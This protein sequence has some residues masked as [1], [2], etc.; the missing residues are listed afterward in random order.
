VQIMSKTIVNDAPWA[1]P[2][3]VSR[4]RSVISPGDYAYSSIWPG[5]I[6]GSSCPSAG[7]R[8]EWFAGVFFRGLR[9]ARRCSRAVDDG[10]GVT[11]LMLSIVSISI[12][13]NLQLLIVCIG[14]LADIL[15]RIIDCERSRAWIWLSTGWLCEN[16]PAITGL[17]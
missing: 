3:P 16:Q 1:R 12:C 6:S 13:L 7:W 17:H 2:S 15:G 9:C 14:S 4:C 5:E 10:V 11:G 8:R